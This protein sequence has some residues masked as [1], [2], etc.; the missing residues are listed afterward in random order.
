MAMNA[1]DCRFQPLWVRKLTGKPVASLFLP[2]DFRHDSGFDRRLRPYNRRDFQD[3]YK[4]LIPIVRAVWMAPGVAALGLGVACQVKDFN[5]SP[6]D[7]LAPEHFM[8]RHGFTPD[9][10]AIVQVLNCNLQPVQVFALIRHRLRS[11]CQRSKCSARLRQPAPGWSEW[12][13]ESCRHCNGRNGG[14]SPP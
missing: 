10:P 3:G 9:G 4:R 8:H 14:Q 6:P 13:G 7:G 12:Q 2:P 1:H 11:S 5:I